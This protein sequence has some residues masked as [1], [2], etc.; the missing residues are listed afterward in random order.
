MIIQMI[1]NI[2]TKT[3]HIFCMDGLQLD[4]LM[5]DISENYIERTPLFLLC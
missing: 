4:W 2:V 3:A 5:T 1:E